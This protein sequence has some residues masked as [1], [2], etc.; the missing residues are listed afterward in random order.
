[1]Q[2][3]N[4]LVEVIQSIIFEV[5]HIKDPMSPG[6]SPIV[7]GHQHE[8]FISDN[9]IELRI[10]EAEVFFL[11]TSVGRLEEMEDLFF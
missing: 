10:V 9:L 8:A 2:P 1:M 7:D 6:C 5:D 11:V 4:M 3:H